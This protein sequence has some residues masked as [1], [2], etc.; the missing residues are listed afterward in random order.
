MPFSGT[1]RWI[2]NV[3]IAKKIVFMALIW[4]VAIWILHLHFNQEDSANKIIS[5]GYMPVISNL[6]APVLDY[7]TKDSDEL[8]FRAIKYASFAE[9]VE[10][11]RNDHIQA[12]FI[13]AP[14]SI[15]LSQQGESIRIVYIG[16]RHESTLVARKELKINGVADLAGRTVAVPM[17]YS[18]HN[19]ALLQLIEQHR[20]LGK[21]NIVEMNP[22]DMAASLAA[23]SLD[24][25]FVGEPFAAQTLKSG[26]AE[27]VHYVEEI[28]K[29][30]ICNLLIV[31]DSFILSHPDETRIMVHAA[32]RSGIW[33]QNNPREAAALA[34]K[35][36][37][38]PAELVQFALSTPA[39]RIVLDAFTPKQ[40]E[41]Q[42][43]ADLMVD[44]GLLQNSRI[45][46]L[47]EDRFARSVDLNG[48]T[49]L[50]SIL[51]HAQKECDLHVSQ[52]GSEQLKEQDHNRV[53]DLK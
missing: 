5:M 53:T 33:A 28:W 48:I 19:I 32:V 8:R 23:G 37:N 42:S 16:N 29:G 39:S 4:V 27:V 13:I 14:L 18:G 2:K 34:S 9:M 25:Y 1:Y 11:F 22:P 7:L 31:K 45:D 36:W 47:V 44:Y 40:A 24:A 41:L 3:S 20:I 21:V 46:G 38:Q 52:S 12:A 26:D 30:F 43:M 6:S 50:E 10:S 15:V 17:K 49:S 51:I 35:Y